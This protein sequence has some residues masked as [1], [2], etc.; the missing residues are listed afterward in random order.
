MGCSTNHS[1][2]FVNDIARQNNFKH[3]LSFIEIH[4][5]FIRQLILKG[6]TYSMSLVPPRVVARTTVLDARYSPS[7]Y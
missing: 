5:I 6:L 1:K 3:R 7:V 2:T 4:H